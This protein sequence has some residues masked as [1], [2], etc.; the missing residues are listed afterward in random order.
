[1]LTNKLI[2]SDWTKLSLRVI[3]LFVTAM[4]ISYSP[5]YLREFFG[6]QAR[7]KDDWHRGMMDG[8]WEWG[9]RHYLYFWMNI[10]LF[11]IQAIKIVKWAF[12]EKQKFDV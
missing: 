2:L 7:A 4:L 1:M 9:F 11:I 5:D 3:G 6:D 12:N 10:V 8:M